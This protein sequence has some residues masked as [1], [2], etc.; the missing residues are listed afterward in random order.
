MPDCVVVADRVETD[1]DPWPGFRRPEP[2]GLA[3]GSRKARQFLNVLLLLAATASL[4]IP[5]LGTAAA[6]SSATT[7]DVK[8]PWPATVNLATPISRAKGSIFFWTTPNWP[9]PRRKS[10]TFLS[11][12]WV[13][14][15][16][17]Y[18]AI[19]QGWW[20]PVGAES[21]YFVLSNQD[22]LSC[23][24][25]GDLETGRR[26]LVGVTW[27]TGERGFCRIYI[28]GARVADSA[29]QSSAPD[30][31]GVQMSV[32][33]DA[34]ATDVRD[35]VADA[36][37]GP[38]FL[39]SSAL[40]DAAVRAFHASLEGGERAAEERRWSWAGSSVETPPS[41]S[42]DRGVR[43]EA[44]VLF[45]ESWQW[46]RSRQE[47][48]LV[49]ARTKRAGFNVLVP[50]VWLG[51]GTH[52]PSR[53]AEP[54]PELVQVLRQGFDP[55]EYLIDRAHRSGLEVHPMFTI[56]RRDTDRWPDYFGP[57]VPEGAFNVHDGR[58][59]R[60][61][62]D[63]VIDVVR[64]YD[65]DGVNLDYIRTMGI[66]TTPA[67][68]KDY[69]LRYGKELPDD[70]REV[71]VDTRA[72]E[73]LQAW[74]DDAVR[75]IVTSVAAE[76]RVARPKVLISVAG[77]PVASPGLRALQGRDEIGWVKAGLVDLV[78]SMQ[79]EST[80]D[81]RNHERVATEIG[82]AGHVVLL[83][84]NFD[85]IDGV[86]TARPDWVVDRLARFAQTRF[87]GQGVGFYLRAMLNDE[88][89]EVLGNGAFRQPAV[90]HWTLSSGDGR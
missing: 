2:P 25:P 22:Y 57:G 62:A 18:M 90:P 67:C 8:G 73:R 31:K 19:S 33:S 46:A 56:A 86:A 72:R 44:R 27:S 52:Y 45:D 54:I 36:T 53:V 13:D 3:S 37:I 21:L 39:F 43:R 24:H 79:Y 14:S 59:R 32:G 40:D 17:S 29:L 64:R 58:F 66:C 5:R 26:S 63:V 47:I 1:R 65:V 11:M 80:V 81:I 84:A 38:L 69:R 7:V 16:Q 77:N 51:R 70:L 61:I 75:A 6:E 4:G 12:R 78:Y 88:Q 89:V 55:L 41:A 49:V 23:S 74:Q 50:A 48:D 87:P 60:F 15:R 9:V 68:K 71:G 42:R 20:E 30:A 35:R 83:L 28:N 82:S 10:S 85:V 34:A 76:A